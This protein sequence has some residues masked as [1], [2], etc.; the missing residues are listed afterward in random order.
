MYVLLSIYSLG[1]NYS[2][3]MIWIRIMPGFV[4]HVVY[5]LE[6]MSWGKLNKSAEYW[7]YPRIRICT[8]IIYLGNLCIKFENQWPRA[9][10]KYA[11]SSETKASAF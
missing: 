1:N 4:T 11:Y 5:E 6:A 10:I 2:K 9:L 3:Q 7:A 8:L